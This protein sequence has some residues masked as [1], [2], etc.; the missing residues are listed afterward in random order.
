LERIYAEYRNY[1]ENRGVP[2]NHDLKVNIREHPLGSGP[3]PSLDASADPKQ[4]ISAFPTAP[5]SPQRG[6]G[7][8]A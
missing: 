8:F 4:T 3:Y 7:A 6:P 2:V 1:C 5:S